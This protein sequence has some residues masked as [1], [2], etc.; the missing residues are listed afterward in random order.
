MSD[1]A[2]SV[3][4]REFLEL[5]S[6][7]LGTAAI[8]AGVPQSAQD[9]REAASKN[10]VTQIASNSARP[11][12]DLTPTAA[13]AAPSQASAAGSNEVFHVAIFRFAK[14]HINDAMAAFRQLASAS[15][16]ESGNLRY[17]IYRGIDD[18]QEFYVVEH[19]ASPAALAAHERTEAFIHFGQGVLV[20]YATLHDTVTARAFDVG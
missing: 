2:G 12:D 11:P 17:D 20:R 15:R 4:R 19:W 9:P 1:D 5:G 14:E 10:G 7:V 16:R 8:T 3:S 6:A 13:A 18:D